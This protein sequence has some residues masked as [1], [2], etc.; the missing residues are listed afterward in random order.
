MEVIL[1]LNIFGHDSSVALIEKAKGEV[2]YALAEERLSN[3][4]HSSLFPSGTL[5]Q[6]LK[7]IEDQ[8]HSLMSIAVNYEPSLFVGGTLIQEINRILGSENK[9]FTDK[10]LSLLKFDEYFNI[11]SGFIKKSIDEILE[12]CI[13]SRTQIEEISS[14]IYCYFNWAVSKQRTINLLGKKF[15]NIPIYKIS[16]HESHSYCAY[17][18]SGYENATILTLDGQ[19]ESETFTVSKATPKGIEKMYSSSWPYS[20]GI[21]YWFATLY[22]GFE[23][24]DEFKVMGMSAYG[25]PIFYDILRGMISVSN[26]GK[27]VFHDNVYFGRQEIDSIHGHFYYGF[28][29]KFNEIVPRRSAEQEI[30]QLHFDLAASLQKLTEEIGVELAKIAV[31][32]TGFANIAMAGGVAL[33]GLMNERIRSSDFCESLFVY[34]ASGDDGGAV[35]AAQCMAFK[36]N[37]YP[38]KK[39]HTVFY[40]LDYT[41]DVIE[42]SIKS[43]GLEYKKV[44][45]IHAKI[46]EALSKGFIVARFFSRSEFGPRALGHRSILTDPRKNEMKDILNER[47]KHR[48]MFRPFAPACL[49]EYVNEY[50]EIQGDADFMLFIVQAKEKSK[51]LIP[52]VVHFD[53]TARVQTVGKEENPD[54]YKTISEFHKITG[55]PVVVNTSFNVNGEAIVETPIDA[56]ESFAHMD[57]D[58]L[59]I[60]DYW[61]EKSANLSNFPSLTDS[62]LIKR[63]KYRFNSEI[64][65]TMKHYDLNS[66]EFSETMNLLKTIEKLKNEKNEK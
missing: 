25:S 40:G 24:G 56:I 50:F 37:P 44:S 38:S 52:A 59:A 58:Y 3:E 34:P 46:A 16:H 26:E 61:I 43:L 48:E 23:T 22:L 13:L 15:P 2:I 63:R 28:K 21:F 41:N 29:E 47:I 1:G 51:A 11:N 36:E 35:G 57:I 32:K 20:L 62:E 27:L 7:I 64:V 19:G 6:A 49:K 17:L 66:F 14:R 8:K 45:H 55:I 54:F 33:N 4:K 53:N 18:N 10:I 42:S 30:L 9:S 60:G 5:N 31:R 39:I 65:D 12:S